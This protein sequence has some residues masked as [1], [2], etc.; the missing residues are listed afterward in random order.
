MLVVCINCYNDMPI[1]KQTVESVYSQVDRIIAVD[2]RYYDFPD[3][4]PY[5]TDGTIEY[6][7]GLDKVELVFSAGLFESDKRNVYMDML[8]DGD[9][10]LVLDGDEYIKG[11]ISPLVGADIGLVYLG[12]RGGS[13][14]RIATRFFKYRKGLRHNGIHFILEY[15]GRWFNNRRH[16]VNGFKEKNINTFR[17]HHLNQLRPRSRKEQKEIY[18]QSA[19]SRESQFKIMPYE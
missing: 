15:G 8:N 17:I 5:S 6:L 9:T 12:Q 10:V 19:R 16:A 13:Y 7:S 11:T 14:R 18:K 2:G 4:Q 1:L 3:R